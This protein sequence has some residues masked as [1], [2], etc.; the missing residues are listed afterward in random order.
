M[1]TGSTASTPSRSVEEAIDPGAVGQDRGQVVGG[2]EA[3]GLGHLRAEVGHL[4]HLGRAW[5]PL[6]SRSS[7]TQSTGSTLVY[8]D[9]GA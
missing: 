2:V 6:P 1:R 5:R 3:G 4:D 8:S 7:V 9:P